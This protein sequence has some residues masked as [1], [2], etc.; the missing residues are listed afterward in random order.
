MGGARRPLPLLLANVLQPI[1]GPIVFIRNLS[2]FSFF[3][4]V[5]ENQR[6]LELVWMGEKAVISLERV[7]PSL[8]YY[9]YFYSLSLGLLLL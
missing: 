4:G 2:V 9:G 6:H 1:C 5:S 3:V 7:A 8:Y